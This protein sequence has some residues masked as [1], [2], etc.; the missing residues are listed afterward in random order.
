MLPIV[1]MGEATNASASETM[2]PVDSITT[3]TG[4]IAGPPCTDTLTPPNERAA[5][6]MRP[7]RYSMPPGSSTPSPLP[8]AA[9]SAGFVISDA[10]ISITNATSARISMEWSA[11]SAGVEGMAEEGVVASGPEGGWGDG[12][13]GE[14]VGV[15]GFGGDGVGKEDIGGEGRGANGMGW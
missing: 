1:T 2:L 11:S 4:S 5:A 7:P 10:C 15:E 3:P 13:G 8:F 6:F 12:D 9:Y 14:D